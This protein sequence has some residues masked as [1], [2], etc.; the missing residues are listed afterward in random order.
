MP[1]PPGMLFPPGMPPVSAA[2][3]PGMTPAEEIWVENK[4]PEGKVGWAWDEASGV[5]V[6]TE[7]LHSIHTLQSRDYRG[8]LEGKRRRNGDEQQ[9]ARGIF[10]L[11][12][13]NTTINQLFRLSQNKKTNK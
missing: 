12:I 8:C 9:P 2:A 11:Q 7:S 5:L 13:S 6:N 10:A 1:P 4:T 3:A